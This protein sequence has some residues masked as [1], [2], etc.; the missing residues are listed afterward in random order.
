MENNAKYGPA[1]Q[2]PEQRAYVLAQMQKAHPG[3]YKK[4]TAYVTQLYRRYVAGELSW[5]DVCKMRES[6]V[7]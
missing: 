5:Q 4:A 6:G 2:T 7:Q 1:A 3:L